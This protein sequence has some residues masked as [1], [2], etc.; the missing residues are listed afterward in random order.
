MEVSHRMTAALLPPMPSRQETVNIYQMKLNIFGSNP[1]TRLKC[2]N[3]KESEI[4]TI[5]NLCI[6]SPI[7]MDV[8]HDVQSS[9]NQ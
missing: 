8:P 6:A 5:L 1:Q 4:V 9:K 3:L 7:K 2:G